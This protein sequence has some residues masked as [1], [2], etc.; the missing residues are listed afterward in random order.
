M[1]AV[2]RLLICALAALVAAR[3]AAHHSGSMFEQEKSIELSGTVAEFQWGNPHC[4]IQLL[5]PGG[6]EA[7]EWSVEMGAPTELFRNGWR[8]GTLKPGDRIVV[9]VH[10][11]R[12]GTRGGLYVS[13][14]RADGS[15][16]A[17]PT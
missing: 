7:T 2:T 10:P 11:M 8:P 12:D 16:I 5:V 1:K 4:W 14:K 15:S 13:A 6:Q 3:V 9:V 17:N